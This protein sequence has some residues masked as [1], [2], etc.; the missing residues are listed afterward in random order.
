MKISEFRKLIREEVRKVVN[1][2]ELYASY[3][4]NDLYTVNGK[5]LFISAAYEDKNDA[6]SDISNIKKSVYR[7]DLK[8]LSDPAIKN[9][10]LQQLQKY[11][12]NLAVGIAKV[13]N[14]IKLLTPEEVKQITSKPSAKTLGGKVTNS[15]LLLVMDEDNVFSLQKL[16][17]YNEKAGLDLDGNLIP[18]QDVS[19]YPESQGAASSPKWKAAVS[20]L[21]N[22]YDYYDVLSDAGENCAV[23]AVPKK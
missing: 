1:E 22:M 18:T 3:D 5:K 12:D 7:D 19:K 20:K 6:I 11:P 23:A 2:V 14:S 21:G 8:A 17:Q 13:G 10:T 15:T 9:N 16:N 4:E